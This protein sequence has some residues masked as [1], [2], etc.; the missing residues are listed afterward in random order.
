MLYEVLTGR[1]PFEGEDLADT[2][3][4][5]LKSDPDWNALPVDVPPHIRLLIQRCLAK[6]KRHRIADMSVALFVLNEAAGLAPGAAAAGTSV[7]APPPRWRRIVAPAAA[8]IVAGAAVGTAVWLA[9]RVVPGTQVSRFEIT[10]T[11]PAPSSSP[12]SPSTSPTRSMEPASCEAHDKRPRL[13]VRSLDRSNR[14][15]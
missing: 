3:A 1:R 12:L 2:L 9:T 13:F 8:A 5:V 10:P 11:G 14:Q 4:T 6:D 15:R 7:V